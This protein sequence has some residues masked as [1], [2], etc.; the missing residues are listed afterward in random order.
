YLPGP[1]GAEGMDRS[2]ISWPVHD[3][4]VARIDQAARQQ[5]ESLLRAGDHEHVIGGSAKASCNRFAK[6]RLPLGGAM[7]P[8]RAAFPLQRLVERTAERVGGKTLER[9]D[10]GGE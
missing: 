9:R 1:G 2:E 10:A 4:G 5:I 6:N 7:P 3:D 8:H